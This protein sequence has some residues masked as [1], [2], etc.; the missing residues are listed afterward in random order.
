MLAADGGR[1]V[2]VEAL[3]AARLDDPEVHVGLV[4]V[5]RQHDADVE[6]EEAPQPLVERPRARRPV[7]LENRLNAVGFDER[8]DLDLGKAR[9]PFAIHDFAEEREGARVVVGRRGGARA[10]RPPVQREREIAV[11]LRLLGTQAPHAIEEL[12]RHVELIDLREPMREHPQQPRV[13]ELQLGHA[14][15]HADPEIALAVLDQV[16]G[17]IKIEGRTRCRRCRARPDTGGTHR[18]RLRAAIADTACRDSRP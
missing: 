10:A 5:P 6:V 2:R 14:G 16:V 3:L 15:E 7:A 11:R 18:P 8:D 13:L 9:V 4:G 12:D 17:T 1:R